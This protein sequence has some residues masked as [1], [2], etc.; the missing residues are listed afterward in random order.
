MKLQ[1]ALGA[2]QNTG[3]RK[4]MDMFGVLMV[5]KVTRVH[6]KSGTADVTIIGTND[7][8]K[9]TPENEG[10]FSARILQRSSGYDAVTKKPWGTVDPI[11]E[12]SMVLLTFLDGVKQRPVILGTFPRIDNME[13]IYPAEYPLL[14]NIQGINTR[15]ALQQL[16]V[17]PAGLFTKLDGEGNY[18]RTFIGGSFLVNFSGETDYEDQINDMH[19]GYNATDLT[20]IDKDTGEAR[21]PVDESPASRNGKF[22]FGHRTVIDGRETYVKFYMSDTGEL[23]ITRDNDDGTLSYFE[24]SQNGAISL[25]RQQ[26]GARRGESNRES[27]IRIEA[28]GDIHMKRDSSRL[29]L[30]HDIDIDVPGKFLTRTGNI[31][32]D[33]L[34]TLEDINGH[35]AEIYASAHGLNEG[36]TD[37]FRD[38]LISEAEVKTISEALNAMHADHENIMAKYQSVYAN[39]KLTGTMKDD[40]YT[41]GTLYSNSYSNLRDLILD[42]VV[43]GHI[44]DAEQ[45]A[46]VNFFSDYRTRIGILADAI[47]VA[48]DAIVNGKVDDATAEAIARENAIR[49]DVEDL[50][51]S[52][53]NFKQTIEDSFADGIISTQEARL[54]ESHKVRLQVEKANITARYNE[55]YNHP[56]LEGNPKA[57]LESAYHSFTGVHQDLIEAIDNAITDLEITPQES[58]EVNNLFDTYQFY[59]SE[60]VTGFEQSMDAINSAKANTAERVAKLHAEQKAQEAQEASEAYALAKAEAERIIA[61]AYADG[62]VTAEEQARIADANAKLELARQH[63]EQKAQEAQEAS[64][65]YARLKAG[66]AED[67]AKAHADRI[68]NEIDAV[69]DDILARAF[70]LDEA[71][72]DAF[73]DGIISEAEARILGDAIN[74]INT[75]YVQLARRYLAIFDSPWLTGNPKSDLADAK[76]AYN[77]AYADMVAHIEAIITKGDVTNLD[78][79][80]YDALFIAYHTAIQDLSEAFEHAVDAITTAKAND[81]E[82]NAKD[83][84]DD[85]F[86]DLEVV[87]SQ[88]TTA[89]EKNEQDIVLRATRED[90]NKSNEVVRNVLSELTVDTENGL[91]YIFDD[92]GV[93]QGYTFGPDGFMLDASHI[94][95]SAGSSLVLSID[96]ARTTAIDT[97]SADATSKANTAEANAIAHANTKAGEA[98]T[99][100]EE[101]ALAQAEAERLIAESYA[102]GLVTAEESARIADANAKLQEAKDHA[103]AKAQEAEDA[104]KQHSDTALENLEIGARNLLRNSRA[105]V[106]AD[107]STTIEGITYREN[108]VPR[109]HAYDEFMLAQYENYVISVWMLNTQTTTQTYDI[110]LEG[111]SI[112]TGEW[113]TKIDTASL[114]MYSAKR[115]VFKIYNDFPGGSSEYRLYTSLNPNSTS[116]LSSYPQI[117]L[118]T[119]A[120]DYGPAQADVDAQLASAMAEIDQVSG[121]LEAFTTDVNGFIRDG[122]IEEAEAK[123]IKV[124]L[125]NL[126]KEKADVDEKY[127]ETYSNPQLEGLPKTN[128]LNAKVTYNSAHADLWT[129]VT[130]AIANSR[131][132]D[133]EAQEID[134]NLTAYATALALLSQRIEQA[135]NAIVSAYASDA[136]QTAKNH[137]DTQ[138]GN[139]EANAIAHANTKAQEAQDASEAYAKAK[140]EAERVLAEAYADGVVSTEESARIADVNAKMEDA[141]QHADTKAQEAENAATAVANLAQQTADGKVS[142][143]QITTEINLQE[144]LAKIIAERIEL[145][146]GDLF[147]QDGKVFIR[148][149]RINSG[150]ITELSFS[151]LRGGTA[152]LG[153]SGNYGSLEV[154]DDTDEIIMKLDSSQMA[155]SEMAVSTLYVEDLINPNIMK[156]LREDVAFYVRGT[157]DDSN[158][159]LSYSSPKRT[160]QG[161]LDDIPSQLYGR[162]HIN[163]YN[164]YDAEETVEIAGFSGFGHIR[165]DFTNVTTKI[166]LNFIFRANSCE[167]YVSGSPGNSGG[168]RGVSDIMIQNDTSMYLYIHD[169]EMQGTSST[170]FGV[171]SIKGGSTYCNGV[172]VSNV[173]YGFHTQ[174]LGRMA[175]VS[176]DGKA[177]EV[178]I[179][180]SSAG[181]HIFGNG[182]G[183]VGNSANTREHSA[184]LLSGNWTFPNVST[185]TPAPV[186]RTRKKTWTTR[187]ANHYYYGSIGW[188]STFMRDY[189]I[190]GKW[191][192][193]DMRAGLWYFGS[194]MRNTLNGKTIKRIRVSIGRSTYK[195]QGYTGRRT[196]T[197]R[198]H[199]HASKQSS[200]TP[201]FSNTFY[202]G[203]LAMG[204][205]RWFDVTSEFD[206]LIR[207]GTW[208]GFGVRVTETSNYRYMAM[209]KEIR[210]E[211]TYEE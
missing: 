72:T 43:A 200:G 88:H 11:S 73:R 149:A 69:L 111:R 46:Y 169:I 49:E 119:K 45:S 65:A 150:H 90:L 145:G 157:G 191:G 26:G 3:N 7:K 107:I 86:R 121:A 142:P 130:D 19:K 60:L 137:A 135:I 58:A 6:H 133:A 208:Y 95:L 210:V 16:S 115:H 192:S 141:K 61:E 178:G 71:L 168:I 132:T 165:F 211:V 92:N 194:D 76:T 206:S 125:Q 185:P 136:E 34:P 96:N 144:G 20:V 23:R 177:R 68:K 203:D 158:D 13:N 97:A 84:A 175:V 164:S 85:I 100:A 202:Q 37:A 205:R 25:T 17:S 198:M 199:K 154:L 131:V 179:Y 62:I 10:R 78:R 55:I 38:D 5:G 98:Q 8:I 28:D 188:N 42:I 183:P 82:G 207:N 9:S 173:D 70:G 102:D 117:E 59:M 114:P 14:E 83:H 75:E 129:S 146:D 101:Y 152:T 190:Q 151:D 170:A 134:A 57:L 171:Q 80:T 181:G 104:S 193:W 209:A 4:D 126:N 24:F 120:T 1:S 159:G 106:D 39:P 53:I 50:E 180:A 196:F 74:Q 153:G 89:I 81:A 94:F 189:P 29:S 172:K 201:E 116:I 56:D 113:V 143:D 51:A 174:Y 91:Q 32:L 15:E 48:W 66:E 166:P 127:N 161:V 44:T 67:N 103:D 123:A 52:Y 148:D 54:I 139:A 112:E 99:S 77:T 87:Q 122:I 184:G 27:S 64:E 12:G 110:I 109:Q 138:A 156:I 21:T 2:F 204:E 40:L 128:L 36:I 108:T 41:A 147:V 155:S 31:S 47:E 118:G 162:V 22:L 105:W 176:C 163:L 35:I 186:V 124:H 182:T 63:A 195:T 79:Q 93:V 187:T 160:I 197:L 140:A 33:W 18:E 30:G 167:L